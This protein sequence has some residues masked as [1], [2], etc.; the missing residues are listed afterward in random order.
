MMR[1]NPYASYDLKLKNKGV[2]VYQKADKNGPVAGTVPDDLEVVHA[3]Y[4]TDGLNNDGETYWSVFCF[5]K[6]TDKEPFF[7]LSGFVLQNDLDFG[8]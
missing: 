7:H 1:S 6:P 4:A 3:H 5:R 2:V 8:E